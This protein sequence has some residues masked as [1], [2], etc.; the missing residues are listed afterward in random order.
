MSLISKTIANLVNGVSQQPPSIRNPTQCELQENC[1]SDVTYGVTHRPHSEFVAKL[2]SLGS[3]PRIPYFHNIDRGPGSQ[4][5]VVVNYGSVKVFDRITGAAKTVS[6]PNGTAYLNAADPRTAFQCL[7]VGTKTYILN[8]TVT[9]AE[10][11][12]PFTGAGLSD[13]R[14]LEQKIAMVWIKQGDYSTDYNVSLRGSLYDSLTSTETAVYGPTLVTK[15]TSATLA[16]DIKTTQIASDLATGITAANAAFAN[17]VLQTAVVVDTGLSVILLTGRP[18]LGTTYKRFQ[19]YVSDSKG[20]QNIRYTE[21]AV[22]KFA[23]LPSAG[24]NGYRVRVAGDKTSAYD[25]Y[26]VKFITDDANANTGV[27]A[28]K[29]SYWYGTHYRPLA[30]TM[31]MVLIDNLDGTFTCKQDTWAG[32]EAGDTITNPSPSF[33]GKALTGM[34]TFANRM[35]LL[36]DERVIMSEVGQFNN[37]YLTSVVTFLDSDPIDIKE[38]NGFGKWLYATPLAEKLILFSAKG[39]AVIQ[40]DGLLT[41]KTATLKAAT[42]YPVSDTC[43]PILI[44]DNIYFSAKNGDFTRLFEFFI[45]GNIEAFRAAEIT[46]HVPQYLPTGITRLAGDDAAK[47]IVAMGTS[48]TGTNNWYDLWIYRYFWVGDQKVQSS[49]SRWKFPQGLMV[50]NVT[51][52]DGILYFCSMDKNVGDLLYHKMDL[53]ITKKDVAANANTRTYMDVRLDGTALSSSLAGTTRTFTLP[54][55]VLLNGS[56]SLFKCYRKE[57]QSGSPRVSWGVNVPVSFVGPYNTLSNTVTISDPDGL[58]LTN[59]WF[60]FPYTSTYTF[61]EI[62]LKEDQNGSQV[63]TETGKLTL[64]KMDLLFNNTLYFK[65]QVTPSERATRTYPVSP[66][67]IGNPVALSSQIARSGRVSIPVNAANNKVT[68]SVINDSVVQHRLQ[69][70]EW[71]GN[72]TI[73]SRRT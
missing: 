59:V 24:Y 14:N 64:K 3:S 54:F 35:G 61:S 63:P 19:I 13:S 34:F 42:R 41:P 70:A 52:L 40:G 73:L 17:S 69:S 7:T 23:D 39:Q 68:I 12:I 28:W 22:Q 6:F 57:N 18:A 1:L 55:S 11:L 45:Q 20:N 58:F 25:D 29:E 66:Y 27:G 53:D 60:G 51:L 33:I 10:E 9:T 47:L 72:Y 37:Y 50:C 32:R 5:E 38:L 2:D 44:G 21:G 26:Y 62:H 65:T 56:E 15:S 71:T 8:K 67:L 43:D 46:S 16:T 30:S 36:C 48:E 31:P 49:W 4:Y